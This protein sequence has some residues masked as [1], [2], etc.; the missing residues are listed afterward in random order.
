MRRRG[1]ESA[2]AAT[3]LIACLLLAGTAAG[4]PGSEKAQVD[5]Q[6]GQLRDRA[7]DAERRAGVLTEELSAVAGRVRQ[8]QAG[9]SAQQARLDVLENTLSRARTRLGTLDRRIATQTARLTRL[10]GEYRAALGRLELRVRELYM[11]DRPDLI[12][13][14]LGTA[15][16][17]DLIDNLEL[18][19]RIGRQDKRIAAQVRGA[20]DGV[21]EARRRARIA[22]REAARIEAA[23]DAAATEQRGVVIRLVASRDALV[24]AEQAKSATLASIEDGQADVHAEIEALEDRSAE[25]AAQ[26][27]QSQQESSSSPPIP[28]PSGNGIL[29]WP[30]SGTVVSG[31][32]MRWGRMHEGIDITAAMNTPVHASA[33]GRVINAGWLG[34]YG[35]LVVVDHGGG[36]STAYAHNT[37]FAVSVGDTVSAGQVIAYSGSTGNSS[38]PHVHFEVRVNGS[39]VDPLGYL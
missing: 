17:T 39:A 19:G 14:V 18:L 16:F 12:A 22:R 5:G 4:D 6:L 10:R 9:V 23:A 33:A 3:V 21:R 27:R 32:G 37:S 25:L 7:A 13:F 11:S 34:G 2:A 20:R 35:N 1:L 26:I 30:V 8:L 31:F 15:S 28:P 29:G 24:A 38:G 36:L